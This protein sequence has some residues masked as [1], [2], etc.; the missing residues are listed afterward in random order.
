MGC[1]MIAMFGTTDLVNTQPLCNRTTM[2][3]MMPI[4]RRTTVNPNP[5]WESHLETECP[6]QCLEEFIDTDMSFTLVSNKSHDQ[7]W[8]L[9][10]LPE[11]RTKEEAVW[12]ELFFK[13]LNTHVSSPHIIHSPYFTVAS[14][15]TKYDPF[16]IYDLLSSIGGTLGL[17]LGGSIFSI[18]ESMLIFIFFGISMSTLAIR[19]AFQHQK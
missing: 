7:A 19:T 6:E 4:L 18:F 9:W 10:Q 13:T 11:G 1:S 12:M 5:E 16:T 3:M 17:F 14:Q 15:V 8:K 2:Q